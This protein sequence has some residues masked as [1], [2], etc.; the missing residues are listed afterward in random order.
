MKNKDIF[1]RIMS[2]PILKR[3]YPF[4]YKNKQILLYLFFG[5][6]TTLISI[7]VFYLLNVTLEVNE[8]ISNLVSWIAA[9]LFAFLTNRVMVFE[10]KTDSAG[11]F[12]YQMLK[13]YMGRVATL[14]VE[15]IIIFIFI[16]KMGLY[17]LAVKLFA[18][19]L[20]IIL[21]YIISKSLIFRKGRD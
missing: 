17:S 8:H 18:Q 13:F 14:L 19:I 6:L 2:L 10:A 21:N 11:A 9:V 1:D 4:Y 20:V 7:A 16:T 3:F 5:G 12:L 15:E